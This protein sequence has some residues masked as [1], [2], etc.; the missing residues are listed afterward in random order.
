MGRPRKPIERHLLDGTYRA[1]RHGPLSDE[2]EEFAPPTKP[3]EMTPAAGEFWD[4]VVAMLAGVVRDRDGPQL[5]QLCSWWALWQEAEAKLMAGS[6]GTIEYART[7][8]AVSVASQNFD[9]IAK[10]FGLTPADRAVL[11]VEH[12]GPPK[13]K[14]A[15]RPKTQLDAKGPP[16]PK[17]GK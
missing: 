16:K 5:A 8:N 15:T 11:K 1:D 3:A 2:P 13:P 9:R 10:R 4:K 12:A 17:K 14:V 7:L 6:P